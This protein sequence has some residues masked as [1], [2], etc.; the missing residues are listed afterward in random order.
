M[1]EGLNLAHCLGCGMCMPLRNPPPLPAQEPSHEPP[2][3]PPSS[4]GTPAL[5][6]KEPPFLDPFLDSF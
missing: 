4:T 1:F 2:R 5:A 6:T 3:E